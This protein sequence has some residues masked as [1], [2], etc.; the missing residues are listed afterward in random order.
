MEKLYTIKEAMEFLGVRSRTTFY[1]I[2]DRL[3]IPYVDLN[4]GGTNE[5]RRF[6]RSDLEHVFINREG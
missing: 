2:M 6:R 5:M 3:S 4:E 1:K